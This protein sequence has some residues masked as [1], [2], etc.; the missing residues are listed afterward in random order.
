MLQIFKS[1]KPL[2]RIAAFIMSRRAGMHV[3]VFLKSHHAGE[4]VITQKNFAT[5]TLKRNLKL[6]YVFFLGAFVAIFPG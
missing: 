2:Y 5:K 6:E 1:L 4:G 3:T